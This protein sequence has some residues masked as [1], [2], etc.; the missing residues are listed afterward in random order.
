MLN[1]LL[2]SLLILF[3]FTPLNAAP[4]NSFLMKQPTHIFVNNRIL[5]KVN[6]KPISVIDLMKKMDLVFYRQF[7]QYASSVEARF[8]FYQANWKHILEELV[9]KE[10]VMA[11]AEENKL[12][13][14]QG[15]IRQEMESIFG[16]NIIANLD[17]AGLSYA[18]ASQLIKEDLTLRRMMSARVHAKAVRTITPLMVRAQYEE[19]AKQNTKPDIWTYQ[20]I[21]FR[22]A[23]AA[24]SEEAAK[25][26]YKAL[27]EENIGLTDLQKRLES[28]S[29]IGAQ[30]SFNIS[31]EFEHA[32][33]D[34]SDSYRESLALLQPGTFSKPIS[35][36][37]RNGDGQVFRIFYLKSNVQGGAKPFNDVESKLRDQLVEQAVSKESDAYMA[38]LR[39]HFD[40]QL[41]NTLPEGFQPFELK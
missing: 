7:P 8:Q 4:K 29:A 39:K 25:A 1:K 27:A 37:S 3:F 32:P 36:L 31:S 13:L 41:S 18:E 14:S 5:A 33:K 35:Q 19:W 40:T 38:R 21:S 9:D 15:D 2:I 23:D 24:K 12:P 16:P 10:L 26:A 28:L 34:V 17:K 30:T 11:D 6:G 22:G 20:V